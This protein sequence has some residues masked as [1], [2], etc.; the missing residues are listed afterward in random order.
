[1]KYIVWLLFVA[2]VVLHQ[3]YWRWNDSRLI[4]GF[5]PYPLAYHTGLSVAA[6]L[7]WWLATIWCWPA[8]PDA[9]QPLPSSVDRQS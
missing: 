9:E 5:L 7:L 1:M 6:A 8:S 3:D 4:A 2:L